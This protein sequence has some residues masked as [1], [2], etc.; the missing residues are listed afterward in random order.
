[1]GDISVIREAPVYEPGSEIKHDGTIH[2]V[3][4]D[5]GGEVSLI[6]PESTIT[7]K[8]GARLR[9]VAGNH[10]LVEKATLVLEGLR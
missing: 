5:L 2:T 9:L 6:C 1:V 4:C 8:R 10:T 3:H 7:T